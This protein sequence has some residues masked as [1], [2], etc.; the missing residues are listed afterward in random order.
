MKHSNKEFPIKDDY[1]SQLDFLKHAWMDGWLDEYSDEH[2]LIRA[3]EDRLEDFVGE[4]QLIENNSNMLNI[5]EGNSYNHH[6]FALNFCI[7]F[8]IKLNAI[9]LKFG[10]NNIKRFITDQLSAGKKN[11]KDHIF[12]EALS[13]TAILFFYMSRTSWSNVIYEPTLNDSSNKNPEARFE[14]DI[15]INGLNRRIAFNIEVKSPA[16]PAM[17]NNDVKIAIPTMLL[18]DSGR[19][20]VSKFCKN[21]GIKYIPPRVNKIKDFLN[22]AASKFLIPNEDEYNILYINWSYSDFPSNSFLEAWGLLTNPYNGILTNPQYASHIEVVDDLFKKVSAVVV[23]T[24]SIEG[25]M[26]SDFSYVWQRNGAGPRFRMWVNENIVKDKETL[27]LITSMNPSPYSEL[28]V[29]MD[30]KSKNESEYVRNCEIAKKLA[31]LVAECK[32]IL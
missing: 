26:Q 17:V 29:M 4:P 22:S 11:Y 16:F 10:E 3:I 14:L 30:M 25:I 12:F 19:S 20:E 7:N 8:S 21:Y 6:S 28:N 23:Y 15:E 9:S 27:T 32:L 1:F 24:E 31:N 2:F 5:W 13:E 18:S